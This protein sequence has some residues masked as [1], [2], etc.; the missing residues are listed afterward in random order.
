M[1]GGW[2]IKYA[3]NSFA[4]NS[5]IVKSFSVDTVQVTIFVAIF[6]LLSLIIIAAG[7]E[8]GIEKLSKILMPALFV[9]LIA[10]VIYSLCLGDGVSEGLAFYLKPDFSKLDASTILLAMGQAFWSLSLG[11]GI[12][13]TYGSYAGEEIN[14]VNS[15]FMI[16]LFDTLV[17]LLAGLVIFPAVAH[18]DSSLLDGS[19]GVTLIYEILPAVF[20]SMGVIGKVVS[21]LF[22][23]M[24][25]IAAITS[26]ISLF[27][28][29]TQFIL[30]KFHVN[31]KIA[32]SIVCVL[33]LL[34]SIPV[35]S[36]LGHVYICGESG[37]SLFGLDLFTVF[38]EVT[39]TVLMP[40]CALMA[41]IAVGWVLKPKKAIAEMESE[42]TRFPAWLRKIYPVFVKFI[43]PAL[44]IIVQISGIYSE[45]KAGNIGIVLLSCGLIALCLVLYFVFFVN[46]YTG[47]NEDE[48]VGRGV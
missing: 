34:I 25:A 43:T 27:E 36:S 10:I 6:I 39:N 18:F 24:V 22:F 48:K 19:K 4:G 33:C 30:Q 44:I 45:L 42:G 29:C 32:I 38:D 11:M 1:L 41:C 7:V 23:A 8:S 20:E 28:V 40:F 35:N 14:L 12:M 9:I 17:A 15:T 47:T 3:V 16:C 31:R 13:I 37:I 46:A 26:V 5:G 21:F 2:S